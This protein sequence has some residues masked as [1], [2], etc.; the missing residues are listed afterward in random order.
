MVKY[1]CDYCGKELNMN[2]FTDGEHFD[3]RGEVRMACEHCASVIRNPYNLCEEKKSQAARQL[4][5]EKEKALLAYK[6]KVEQANKQRD[7]IIDDLLE[8]GY[9]QIPETL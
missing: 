3:Y 6:N 4:E 5:T 7:D 8:G 9:E 2:N 1:F